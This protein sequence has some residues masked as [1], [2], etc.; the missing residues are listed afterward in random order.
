MCVILLLVCLLCIL[1][2][3]LTYVREYTLEGR[4]LYELYSTLFKDSIL[5]IIKANERKKVL[6]TNLEKRY[7]LLSKGQVLLLRR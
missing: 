1:I 3:F 5:K 6:D 2:F 7:N 4:V